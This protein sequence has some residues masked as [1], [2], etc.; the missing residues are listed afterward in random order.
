MTEV[1]SAAAVPEG[2]LG[3]L[4][5]EHECKLRELWALLLERFEDDEVARAEAAVNTTTADLD[6]LTVQEGPTDSAASPTTSATSDKSTDKLK[7]SAKKPL[8]FLKKSKKSKS[9]A[10]IPALSQAGKQDGQQAVA[11]T[12]SEPANSPKDAADDDAISTTTSTNNNNDKEDK[13]TESGEVDVAL[14]AAETLRQAFWK[15]V[16]VDN[17]DSILLRF[18]RARKWDVAKAF[19]MGIHALEWRLEAKVDQVVARGEA[20]LHEGV[21][22]KG[23]SFLHG[24]DKRG[25]PV[26]VIRV[27]LHRKEDQTLEQLTDFLI[28]TI[29]TARLF[30]GPGVETATAIFDLTDFT[31][32]N[33]DFAFIKLLI[34]Y[35]EAY[36]PESL[37]TLLI[38]NAPWIFGS[39]WRMIS[40]LLDPVV[41]SKIN[42][43]RSQEDF[44]E[45]IDA[46]NM[47]D[48]LGGESRF[49]YEYVGPQ[50]DE[51]AHMLDTAQR[52]QA[53]ERYNQSMVNVENA[54]LKWLAAHKVLDANTDESKASALKEEAQ[55]ADQQ[56]QATQT[57]HKAAVKALDPFVRA[58]TFYHRVGVVQDFSQFDW[59]PMLCKSGESQQA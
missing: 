14:T 42:F 47:V 54:T 10:A 45:F 35:L 31:M 12:A 32:A 39:I 34:R 9:T 57:E 37:G 2:F 44:A 40:P 53:A 36:Y 19:E 8:S 20:G 3:N 51:N 11:D 1:Q 33:M 16:Q 18:L 28:W 55:A 38:Y 30:L 21:L 23:I 5:P 41:A 52:T 49:Q 59:K 22:K 58:R 24:Q 29:E 4:T 27:K 48:W 7:K 6:N 43:I 46:A 17:P 15:V 25:R 13:Y 56:R 26:I 50:A